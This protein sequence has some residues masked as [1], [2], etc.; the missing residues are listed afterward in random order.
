MPIHKVS[1]RSMLF[2]NATGRNRNDERKRKAKIKKFNRMPGVAEI[3]KAMRKT[4]PGQGL[5]W[6]P[7]KSSYIFYKN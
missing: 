5:K 6:R 1:V 7:P 2:G 4:K 3:D